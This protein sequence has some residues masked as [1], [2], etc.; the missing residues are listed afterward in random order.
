VMLL[1]QIKREVHEQNSVHLLLL[2]AGRQQG[3][4]SHCRRIL[5]MWREEGCTDGG[6]RDVLMGEWRDEGWA[7]GGKRDVL[8][9]GW[10]EEGCTDG[11]M[12][13]RGKY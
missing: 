9:D 10:R 3:A 11:R 7:D 12:E 2:P 5:F 6:K 8:M 13:G 4:A 1:T